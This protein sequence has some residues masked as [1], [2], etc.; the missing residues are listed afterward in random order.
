MYLPIRNHT[1]TKQWLV[2]DG[3]E[4]PK[5]KSR[6]SYIAAYIICWKAAVEN[7]ALQGV[8]AVYT[9]ETHVDVLG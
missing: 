3:L 7:L 1:E 8:I 2:P 4:H 9:P 5:F 6:R